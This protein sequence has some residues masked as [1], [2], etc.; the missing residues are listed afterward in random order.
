MGAAPGCGGA[1]GDGAA[2]V[3]AALVA[4]GEGA[5]QAGRGAGHRVA[6]ARP[7]TAGEVSAQAADIRGVGG[8]LLRGVLINTGFRRL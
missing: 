5:G 6:A 2:R 8:G 3:G 7:R 4:E 1:P